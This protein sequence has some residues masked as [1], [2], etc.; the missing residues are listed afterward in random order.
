MCGVWNSGE[1]IVKNN[2]ILGGDFSHF[3]IKDKGYASG[4]KGGM[5]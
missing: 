1:I 4:M 3:W 5:P 2:V